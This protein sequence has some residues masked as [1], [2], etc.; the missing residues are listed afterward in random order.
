M[1]RRTFNGT[2]LHRREWARYRSA[3]DG[4]ELLEASFEQHV[5][6]RHIHDTYAFG[7]TRRG[8][9]RFWCRGATHDSVAGNVLVIPPGEVH[10]GESGAEGGYAYRM[11]YVP[12]GRVTALASEAFDKSASSL[13]L[14]R[15]CLLQEPALA[16]ALNTA[17]KAMSAQPASLAA[18]ELFG[19]ALSRLDIRH[20]VVTARKSLLDD[21]ALSRVRDYLREHVGARV[22]LDELAAI[23][24]MSRFRLTR[25][26]EKAY[27]LPLHGYHMHLR[28]LEAKKRLRTGTPIAAVAADLGFAD[29]SHLNRRFKGVFGMTPG[30][31]RSSGEVNGRQA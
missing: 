10:D 17:W 20:D 13:K 28:L 22:R 6:E 3:D 9:Q 8:V 11:F 14:G 5:Y 24:S 4:V 26:F 16:R 21:R 29:Q 23:A 7:V 12:I 30:E 1:D 25:Q 15:S 2:K 31:W 27:G 19:E 18:D